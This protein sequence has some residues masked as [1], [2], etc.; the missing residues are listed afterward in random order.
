[1]L[2]VLLHSHHNLTLI[3]YLQS[4]I[5]TTSQTDSDYLFISASM[6]A[7][8]NKNSA[9]VNAIEDYVP[10]I[11]ESHS[12]C[13]T[14]LCEFILNDQ[15]HNFLKSYNKTHNKQSYSAIKR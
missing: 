1:M 7:L 5:H 9:I 8:L 14:V 6:H 12:S 10:L 15:I 2:N 13:D 11:A 3:T 4:L